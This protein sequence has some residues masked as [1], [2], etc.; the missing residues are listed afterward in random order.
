MCKAKSLFNEGMKV[1]LYSKNMKRFY[2]T[3]KNLVFFCNFI[4]KKNNSNFYSLS[5]TLRFPLDFDTVYLSLNY[6]YT[7]SRLLSFDRY[8]RNSLSRKRFI[9]K[10]HLSY[11]IAGNSFFCYKISD[12]EIFDHEKKIVIIGAR[13]HPGETLSS[14]VMEKI[15]L[16]LTEDL[17]QESIDLRKKY[18]FYIFPMINIDGVVL[19]N[20]RVNI[21]GFDLNRTYIDPSKHLQPTI[22][23]Y[24]EFVKQI[25]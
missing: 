6:P 12:S 2:K 1:T 8:L 17:F 4:K 18:D 24:K 14:H 25:S 16:M 9:L 19:G 23:A 13:V 3:G 11:T 22:Y 5:F 20:Y 10:T 21:S 15:I 7:Y